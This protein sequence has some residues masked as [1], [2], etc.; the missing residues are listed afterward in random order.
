M[1]D[2]S[3]SYEGGEF[4]FP[5][6]DCVIKTETGDAVFFPANYLGAHGVKTVESG[7]RFSYLTQFGQGKE[8]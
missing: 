1:I 5:H 3:E 2:I 7:E 8:D 4:V 6:S